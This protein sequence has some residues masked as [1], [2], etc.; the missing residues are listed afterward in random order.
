MDKADGV[1]E[2]HETVSTDY[3]TAPSKLEQ[4]ARALYPLPS[5]DP[6]D[7]L[8]WPLWL[9]VHCL[10]FAAYLGAHPSE[11]DSGLGTGVRSCRS[12][13]FE[14]RDHQPCLCVSSQRV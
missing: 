1:A 11:T 12:G 13:C 3:Q 4:Q 10:A 6:K 5:N 8:N 14:R 7:P 9:K 2:F